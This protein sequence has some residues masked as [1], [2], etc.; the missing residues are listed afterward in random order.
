LNDD[1]DDREDEGEDDDDD[2]WAEAG[3]RLLAQHFCNFL[4]KPLSK[5][6]DKSYT[7]TS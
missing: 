3:K 5:I 2:D 7:N 1:D 6:H 4:L